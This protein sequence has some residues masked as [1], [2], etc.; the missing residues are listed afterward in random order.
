MTEHKTKVFYDG[1]C[2]ICQLNRQ[3]LHGD[4]RG[5]DALE[6]ID[7]RDPAFYASEYGLN[8]E[9]VLTSLCV[10]DEHGELHEGMDAVHLSYQRKGQGWWLAPT[11]WPLIRR[12]FDL[13]YHWL[14]RHRF[15]I[16]ATLG[17]RKRDRE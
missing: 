10:I 1:D 2:P 3:W 9:Q 12:I 17:I 5:K 13:G 15:R 8:D 4:Q 11:R 16:S 6:L 14:A 7:V